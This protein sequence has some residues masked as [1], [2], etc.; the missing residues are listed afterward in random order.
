VWLDLT[1]RPIWL[2]QKLATMILLDFI[3]LFAPHTSL[4]VPPAYAEML[5]K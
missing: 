5:K 4:W 3:D 2:E 1:S